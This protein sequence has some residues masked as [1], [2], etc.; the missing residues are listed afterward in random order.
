[1]KKIYITVLC[2]LIFQ[3][4]ATVNAQNNAPSPADTGGS[5]S[6]LS[7]NALLLREAFKT[8]SDEKLERFFDNWSKAV[9]SNEEEAPDKYIAEAHKVF[10][11]FYQPLNMEAFEYDSLYQNQPYFI[12]QG[13]LWDISVT[14]N[15]LYTYHELDSFT[16]EYIKQY[17]GKKYW[18]NYL[19]M[20]N[21]QKARNFHRP[22]YLS[23]FGGGAFWPIV[24]VT[25][26][27][28]SVTFRPP[29]NIEGRKIVYLTDEYKAL[30]DSF[31]MDNHVDLGEN[32]IM[33]PA[34]AI[35]ESKKRQNFINRKALIFYG[36]W[37]GYWQYET[38]PK[39]TSIVFD[40]EL[41]RAVV[42]YRI[43]YGGGYAIM[44]KWNGV[45]TFVE[46]RNTW[47]E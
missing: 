17:Y 8:N 45:W 25:K 23:H 24:K 11:A 43:V 38:Y 34:Y 37:G 41:Q 32:N 27:D 5:L 2:L 12:V 44:E 36:H 28:S 42:Q 31:L 29:V 22:S 40:K 19:K 14:D 30:L 1:M 6:Q 10:T 21:E 33:Q 3:L 26:I 9:G 7:D 16:A 46:A 39:A 47:V 15:I 20:D 4:A 13:D 18:K 35:K